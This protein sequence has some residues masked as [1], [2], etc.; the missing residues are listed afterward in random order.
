MYILY[1]YI[2]YIYHIYISHVYIIYISY[3]IIIVIIYSY[4][5]HVYT[6]FMSRIPASIINLLS[7]LILCNLSTSTTEQ[8]RG[9]GGEWKL[10]VHYAF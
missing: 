2:T 4:H 10:I 9:G 3:H 5:I 1:M 6:Y 7:E 8:F